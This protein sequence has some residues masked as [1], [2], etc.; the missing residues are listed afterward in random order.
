M[1]IRA[2][3]IGLLAA[4]SLVAC[5]AEQET[6]TGQDNYEGVQ[7]TRF[8]RMADNMY[9]E[10]NR[11]NRYDNDRGMVHNTNYHVAKDAAVNV[12]K[13]VKGVD[14][15][16]VLKTRDNAYVAAVMDNNSG[17]ENM[18]DKVEEDITKAVKNT[19]QDIN[20]VYVST[21]PDFIDL[22]NNY[23]N[24]VENGEPVRGF[25]QEFGQMV[26]RVFPEA[27]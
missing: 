27:N 21:N 2:F 1:K 14:E 16:Y 13:N 26:D 7:N 3:A 24:D 15:A 12:E 22:T 4:S 5:Q 19:D 17:E 8:Q 9:E 6:G 23:V 10:G 11:T 20:N 25:F 18:T